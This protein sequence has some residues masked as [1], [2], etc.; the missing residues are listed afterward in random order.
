MEEQWRKMDGS[1]ETRAR[2]AV[3]WGWGEGLVGRMGRGASAV[4]LMGGGRGEAR[5]EGPAGPAPLVRS[6]PRISWCWLLST[7]QVSDPVLCGAED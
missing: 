1:G 6:P 7:D 5:G 4:R 2:G 3:G